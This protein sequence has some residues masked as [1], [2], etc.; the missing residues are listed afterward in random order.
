MSKLIDKLS[1]KNKDFDLEYLSNG[2]NATKAYS[3]VYPNAKYVTARSNGAKLLAKTNI[4]E[5]LSDY[6][7]SMWSEKEKDIGKIYNNLIKQATA[8]IADVIE[9]KNGEMR[10]KDFDEIDTSTI[11]QITQTVTDTKEVQRINESI[12]LFDKTKA[13][14]DLIRV[15][16]MIEEKVTVNVNYDKESVGEI[17][18]IF[19]EQI[20][21]KKTN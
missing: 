5:A 15:L 14:S 8:D 4:K 3:K 1:V 11:Q 18:D 20:I 9:Y 19:N 6:F 10:I 17:Q 13:Q 21:S 7:N 12:K 2:N 16:K